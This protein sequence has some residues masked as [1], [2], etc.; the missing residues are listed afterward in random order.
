MINSEIKMISDMN[1]RLNIIEDKINNIELKLKT[2][3]NSMY[4]YYE[5]KRIKESF[6]V[7]IEDIDDIISNDIN[8]DR[9]G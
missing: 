1:D 8:S 2:I 6:E 4:E 3:M 9:L 7:K 5:H